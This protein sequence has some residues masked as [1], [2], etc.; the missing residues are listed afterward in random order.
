MAHTAILSRAL[1]R[2]VINL[3]FS[4]NA[5][6]DLEVAELIAKVTTPSVI[7]L[8]NVPNA[9]PAEIQEK[10]EAF[11]RIIRAAHPA[12]PVV[13][14]EDPIFPHSIV[15]QSI[16]KEIANKNAVQ[17]Q[18]FARLVSAGEKGLY[19]VPAEGLIGDD[20]EATVDGIHLTDLGM[21]RY[22]ERLLPVLE[23]AIKASGR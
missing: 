5:R 8:D 6:L 20:G 9:S 22:A 14:V 7:V 17:A 21:M 10:G 1:D 19:Y 23:Q 13:F 15:D 4:G 2:E 18:L 3:G 11:F 16:E 12:V